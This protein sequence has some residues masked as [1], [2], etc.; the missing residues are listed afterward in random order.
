MKKIF[1]IVTIISIVLFSR[2]ISAQTNDID[3]DDI[4]TAINSF[5]NG[6]TFSG[7]YFLAYQ[8]G[9]SSGNS[10][11][12][13]LLKRGYVTLGKKFSNNVSA[14]ITQDI[15]VDRDGD[16]KGDIE[17]RL[18]YGYIKYKFDDI[19]FFTNSFVEFGLVHRPWLDF[20]QKI[21]IYRVQG[22][23]F[24][25][26][27]DILSSA[28]YGL[29]VSTLFGGEINQEY[30]DEVNSSYPGKY[31]SLS[32]GIYN[33][34][35]YHAI[36]EN[37]NKL[38]E[39]RLSLRPIPELFP[40]LQLSYF[41][42]FG[43]G[44]TSF[45]PDFNFKAGYVSMEHKFFILAGTYYNGTGNEPGDAVDLAG[46]AYK[47]NGYSIFGEAKFF[48]GSFSLFGRYDF[49]RHNLTGWNFD[50]KRI[51][52]GAAYHFLKNNKIILDYD[53]NKL[54]NT[55]A[56]DNSVFEVAIELRY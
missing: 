47:Q 45:S 31:G 48:E 27:N 23:M 54:P 44:N 21:N 53:T 1:H 19:T 32:F 14:R 34:G 17:I 18:K 26:R 13:F 11:N 30:Q 10:F 39:Y 20:E 8:T 5:F 52:A 7:Q 51:I 33:G 2:T 29:F 46:E 3:E 15:S 36:E 40:G 50:S 24:L 49:F 16:G 38:L 28:D 37:Q 43:K 25:E 9:K 22:S 42:A 35:G 55:V 41:G 56:S 6:L 4:K 12:E